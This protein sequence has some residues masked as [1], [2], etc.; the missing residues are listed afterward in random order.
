[1]AKG[2]PAL[3]TRTILRGVKKNG[4]T[5]IHGAFRDYYDRSRVCLMGA[6]AVNTLGKNVD[7]YEEDDYNPFGYIPKLA[8]TLG[9]STDVVQSM[10]YGY[11]GYSYYK[12]DFKKIPR[13]VKLGEKMAKYAVPR[14]NW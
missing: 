8:K 2:N 3:Q 1:M 14:D 7:K 13:Y 11:D 9:V 12:D 4:L 5:L 6:I 10:E